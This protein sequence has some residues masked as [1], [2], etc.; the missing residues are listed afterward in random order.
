MKIYLSKL[1]I[2][3]ALTFID[4]FV[5]YGGL[6]EKDKLKGDIDYSVLGS[7]AQVMLNPIQ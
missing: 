5:A 6:F 4:C 3:L 7:A 2:I 1:L